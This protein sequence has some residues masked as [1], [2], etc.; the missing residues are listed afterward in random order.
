MII[1]QIFNK[2]LRAKREVLKNEKCT[3]SSRDCICSN[4]YFTNH[5]LNVSLKRKTN[6]IFHHHT[7]YDY[8]KR[9]KSRWYTTA[10]CWYT[11]SK[12]FYKSRSPA[13]KCRS[14]HACTIN[15]TELI[16][17]SSPGILDAGI[18][19]SVAYT[20]GQRNRYT[21]CCSIPTALALS[22]VVIRRGMM[23][24]LSVFSFQ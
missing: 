17:F 7:A 12:P 19:R 23:E 5:L 2:T 24:M 20:D 22:A 13:D 8:K 1:I 10:K 18:Q 9:S 16:I 11:T 15:Q 21:Y 4:I 6:D 3:W 14:L